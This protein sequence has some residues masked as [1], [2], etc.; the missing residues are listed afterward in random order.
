MF[1]MRVVMVSKALVVGAYQRKAEEL[2]R[3]GVE[4]TVL[5]PPAWNDRRG[6]QS[7]EQ[8]HMAGYTLRV[9]PLRFNGNYHLH[10]YPTLG[11]ELADLR[12]AVLHMDE[13][14]YN[15]ATFLALRTAAR[16]GI[17]AT[18][19]TWQNLPRRY[20]WPFAQMEQAN[21]RRA[22][23]AI[24]G[25]QAAA[26]VLRGKGYAGEIAVIP[27][28]GVDPQQFAPAPAAP[29]AGAELRIGYAGGLLPEKGVDLLLHACAALAAPW[30]LLVAG[31]GEQRGALEQLAGDLGVAQHVHFLGRRGSDE[32]AAFYQGLDALVLPSRTLPNWTEQFG[33]VLVEAMACAVP[34]VGSRSGEIPHVIGDG[35][36]VFPEGDA[37][38]LAGCLQALAADPAARA[39]LGA[40]GRGRVLAHYT[41]RQIAEQTA[42]VYERLLEA[43]PRINSGARSCETG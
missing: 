43:R 8:A 23:A 1:L 42:A 29:S 40:A 19:F 5:I 22:P 35:G 11:A 34:V 28:F 37:A 20:P 17:R 27:Q 9:I 31:E 41:M 39:R 15:L 30:R 13:E 33:R 25:N 38:A 10:Y 24:A 18:F 32:M 2:A 14:P 16:L 36:L 12:P 7:A 26:A 3:L 4:L 21:Y 6:R